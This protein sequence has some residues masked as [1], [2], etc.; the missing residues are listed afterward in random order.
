MSKWVSQ[1]TFS[2]ST[3]VLLKQTRDLSA[4]EREVSAIIDTYFIIKPDGEDITLVALEVIGEDRLKQF[5]GRKSFNVIK[6]QFGLFI[7]QML[8]KRFGCDRIET[9]RDGRRNATRSCNLGWVKKYTPH[10]IL[11]G[12]MPSH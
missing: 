9:W 5:V 12:E 10:R 2:S 1:S 8:V 3:S 4:I 7:P 6:K 11:P